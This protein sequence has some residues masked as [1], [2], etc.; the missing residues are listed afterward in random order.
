MMAGFIHFDCFC[1]LDIYF[2]GDLASGEPP[3]EAIETFRSKLGQHAYA[4]YTS[5]DDSLVQCPCCN[6][7]IQLP[8]AQIAAYIGEMSQASTSN[9][10]AHSQLSQERSDSLLP[11]NYTEGY[12]PHVSELN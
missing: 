10:Q 11:L 1:G 6:S 4:I 2:F 7:M 12:R 3:V 8:S 9:I 5:K